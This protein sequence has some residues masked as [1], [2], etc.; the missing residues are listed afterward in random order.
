MRATVAHTRMLSNTVLKVELFALL[1][2]VGVRVNVTLWILIAPA[3]ER[4][5][6]A[7]LH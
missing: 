3:A 7:F 5:R 4:L 1:I 2:A 6:A